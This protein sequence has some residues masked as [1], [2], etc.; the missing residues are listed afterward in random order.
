MPTSSFPTGHQRNATPATGTG[1]TFGDD[2]ASGPTA[3]GTVTLAT[4]A[5]IQINKNNVGNNLNYRFDDGN[6]RIMASLSRSTAKLWLRDTHSGHFRQLG[7]ALAEPARVSFSN[8]DQLRPGRIEVFNNANQPIDLS[9][10]NSYRLSTAN[11]TPRDS[12]EIIDGANL[13]VRKQLGFLPVPA[14]FQIGG[15][16]K[17]QTR[18]IRRQNMTWTYNGLDGSFSPAPYI[19]PV[20]KNDRTGY[21]SDGATTPQ[22]SPSLVWAAF[23]KNPALFTQT[24][25]QF[26]AAETFA[27]RNSEFVKENVSALYAQAE[28]KF[29]NGRS[30]LLGGVRYEKTKTEGRGALSDPAAAFVRNADGTFARD[31]AGARIRRPEAGAAGSLENLR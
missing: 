12:D 23:E 5:S 9:N 21:K 22:I 8:I 13:D 3:R 26:V 28:L 6:W 14:S 1:L 31:A 19:S 20:Y 25:A 24:P 7:V 17:T 16:S 11:S 4:G 27:I 2:S 10:V 18:D 29:F 30:Q 15:R